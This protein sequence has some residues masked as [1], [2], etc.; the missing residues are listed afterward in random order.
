NLRVTS[1]IASTRVASC[2]LMVKSL[3]SI[4]PETS[5]VR[6][7]SIPL[8]SIW[9]RLLPSCGRA[10]A[11]TKIAIEASNRD[12]RIF[13]ARAAL[14]FPITRRLAVDEKVNA[15]AGPRFPRKYATNGTASSNRSSQGCAKVNALFP[16]N[17]L[18]SFVMSSEV[19]TSLIVYTGDAKAEKVRDS[20][21]SVGMTACVY[22]R[23][24]TLFGRSNPG[25]LW[26]KQSQVDLLSQ[27]GSPLPV[28]I[29]CRTLLLHTVQ[30]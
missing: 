20:S 14:R 22:V 30:T 11:I 19:E 17:Q 2:P 10:S 18:N 6:I 13:P 1:R 25:R 26:I 12:R 28:T 16:L 3:V 24:D 15:A 23:M 4:D 9:V 8:A 27:N 29:R 5:S 7:M 21:T